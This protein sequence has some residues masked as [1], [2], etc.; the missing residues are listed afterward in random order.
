MIEQDFENHPSTARYNINS[1]VD[2]HTK[3][4]I[5]SILGEDLPQ[6]TRIILANALYFKAIW[7]I[8]FIVGATKLE[9]F[10]PNGEGTEPVMQVETMAGAGAFPYYEDEELNCRIVGLPYSGNMTTMYIMQPRDSSVEKLE[11]LQQ[12]LTPEAIES[13]ITKMIRRSTVVLLPKMHIVDSFKLQRVL[14]RMG[15]TGIFSPVQK[16]LSLISETT[17]SSA[18]PNTRANPRAN[19]RARSQVGGLQSLYNLAAERQAAE[20]SQVP[21]PPSDLIVGDIIHKV[22][23]TVNEQGT[24]AAASSS[25]ILKKSGPEITFRAETPFIVMVRHDL[26]KLPLFYGVINEPPTAKAS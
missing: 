4:K 19:T 17:S 1:W 25:A 16:D 22:D 7:E 15:I 14:K 3:G 2:Q 21:T 20:T 23:F 18:R 13:M 5:R 12:R 10:Y 24:E 26:T 8:D 11:Y 6:E 9:N